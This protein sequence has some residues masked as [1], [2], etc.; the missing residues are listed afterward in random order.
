VLGTAVL[1]A[2]GMAR[3]GADLGWG[4]HAISA[5]YGG[6]AVFGPSLAIL[7]QIVQPN[8]VTVLTAPPDPPSETR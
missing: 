7:T 5:I 3:V 6:D 4:N 1:D 8:T 2:A